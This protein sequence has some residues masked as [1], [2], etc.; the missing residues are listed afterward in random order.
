MKLYRP[1]KKYLVMYI[2][3]LLALW[4]CQTSINYKINY[5]FVYVL[6]FYSFF[7]ISLFFF[8][9]RVKKEPKAYL[10]GDANRIKKIVKILSYINL[11][12]LAYLLYQFYN[13]L[14]SG[15]AISVYRSSLFGDSSIKD[16][17]GNAAAYMFF[18]CTI[19]S[20]LTISFGIYWKIYTA[21]NSILL[22]GLLFL[23]MKEI[24]L[25]SRFY[26]F[27]T[28]L[29]LMLILYC[30][31]KKI[32][33]K[34]ISIYMFL[35]L[36]P[37]IFAFL[38]KSNGSL[39]TVFYNARNYFVVGFSLF[40]N[41]IDSELTD[42]LHYMG[43][44]FAFLGVFST[45]FYNKN[46][47]FEKIQEF[48]SLGDAGY[49]NAF[50]TSFLLPYLYFGF[51]GTIICSIFFGLLISYNLYRLA[52]TQSFFNFNTLFA[53]LLIFF[54]QQFTPVQLTFFWDY[55]YLSIVAQFVR[56]LC[57]RKI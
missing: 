31:D 45:F 11:I 24:V 49:F 57:L 33:R 37:I 22:I 3:I 29:S 48:V 26:L 40:T 17:Y 52:I 7:I 43:S 38:L 28:F 23:I 1:I 15:I 34:R 53:S 12:I 47:F 42:Q 19:V 36:L 2:F 56:R 46:L 41:A 4:V 10:N 8:P 55:F 51:I 30:F 9:S 25:V 16:Y 50:Y 21:E 44:P 32:T 6:L 39:D 54:S 14:Q 27:P 13:I 18:Y 35:L 5:G 20:L